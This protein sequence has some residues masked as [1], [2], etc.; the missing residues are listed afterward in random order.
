MYPAGNGYWCGQY[1]FWDKGT[2]VGD[3]TDCAGFLAPLTNIPV[4][5][6]RVLVL[7][8]GGA[9]RAI[10]QG[11]VERKAAHI[12]LTTP[13]NKRHIA[14]ADEFGAHPLP[15]EARHTIAADM[16]VNTTPVG[17]H[18]SLVDQSPYDM[19]EASH[20]P[21]IAYDIVYNPLETRF[22]REAK[23]HGI[24]TISGRTMFFEQGNAQFN[25]WTGKNLPP[26]AKT[27]LDDALNAQ[28]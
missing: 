16:V 25:L 5:N 1:P 9:A 10:L 26:L 14:L 27:A 22:V 7:G 18:G 6:M 12:D 28:P 4:Q 3:N 8:A 23:Q 24:A 11:L 21:S 2:L 13:S 15:W 17:M 20:L 19:T